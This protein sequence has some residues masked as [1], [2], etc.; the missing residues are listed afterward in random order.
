MKKIYI[1]ILF[2]L[3][4][5]MSFSSCEDYFEYERTQESAWTTTL[6]F[7]SGLSSVYNNVFFQGSLSDIT[8]SG[9]LYIDFLT[10]GTSVLLEGC[11]TS[12]A[13]YNRSFS[14]NQMDNYWKLGYQVVTLCNLALD[15]DANGGGNPFGLDITGEDYLNNYQRQI[16]EFHFLRGWAYW[17]LAKTFCPPYNQNGD[18]SGKFIP[19]KTTAAYSSE[20][21]KSEEFGSVEE[22][23]QQVIADLNAAKEILPE[24]IKKYGWSNVSGFEC[25]R[26]NKFVA[27]ALLGKVYF[28]MG[29]YDLA[30]AEFDEVIEYAENTGTYALE[31]PK[32]PFNKAQASEVGKEV[33]WEQSAGTLGT[34][35]STYFYG[36]MIMGYRMRTSNGDAVDVNTGFVKSTWNAYAISYYASEQMGWLKAVDG[37]YEVTEEAEN[38]LRY[39]QVY[40]YMRPYQEGMATSDPEYYNTETVAGHAAVTTSHL[41][42][43]KFYR[44]PAPYGRYTKVPHIRLADIY[45]LR[46]WTRMNASNLNGAADDMNMVWNRANPD[47]P[48]KYDASIVSH[49]AIYAEY[50]REMMGEGWT[51]DFMMATQMD[52]P[53]GDDTE[54]NSSVSAPYSSWYWPIPE[55]EKELNSLYD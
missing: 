53:A 40:H 39:Q 46:A 44:A 22:I 38:D 5:I 14:E 11:N 1:K 9:Y 34:S 43:D 48:D 21:I 31:D 4:V 23:Y 47:S 6:T 3:A 50:L 10:S 28:L 8:S 2:A 52:I 42:V 33:I 35:N 26:P 7:E 12:A 55:S 37:D 32:E 54:I 36:G 30:N 51:V 45:L 19:F 41:Y 27:T 18:N 29:E 20:D 13:I 16:G 15:L 24:Q 17:Y 25:G 49:D